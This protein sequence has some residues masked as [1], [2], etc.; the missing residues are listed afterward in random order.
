MK[1]KSR[2]LSQSFLLVEVV[3][4][5]FFSASLNKASSQRLLLLISFI[6]HLFVCILSSYSSLFVVFVVVDTLLD[7]YQLCVCCINVLLL[8]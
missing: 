8:G 1:R 5:C 4:P 2:C 7:M 6:S 3:P